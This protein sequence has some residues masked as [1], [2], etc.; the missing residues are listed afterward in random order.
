MLHDRKNTWSSI[1]L[2]ALYIYEGGSCMCRKTLFRNL[3]EYH[4]ENVLIPSSPGFVDVMGFR[5]E[6]AQSLHLVKNIDD[7]V[8]YCVDSVA[9]AVNNE[10]LALKIK[11]NMHHINID[12]G[13]VRE[14]VCDTVALLLSKIISSKFDRVAG[15]D[16][17][18]EHY[19]RD[20]VVPTNRPP[21]NIKRTKS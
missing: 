18:R 21:S 6:L 14:A 16:V 4:G 19:N 3:S 11:R 15:N 1:E 9:S 10:C 13:L 5:S 17:D 20:S 2:F 8:E 7:D 12:K